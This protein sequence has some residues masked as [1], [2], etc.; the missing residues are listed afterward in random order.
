MSTDQNMDQLCISTMRTLSI[1]AIQ[2]AN[3]G[4]PGTPLDAA[5]FAYTLWQQFLRY[6]PADPEWFN[7]DRFVLSAGHGSMLLYAL[8]HL[9]GIKATAPSYGERLGGPA[10][11]LDDL[12]SF[13]Q[14]HS[15]CPGHP[16]Y[17]LT[18]GVEG[19]TGPLGQGV[20]MGVGMA[21]AQSY[22]AAQYNRPGFPIVDFQVYALA[23]DGCMMEGLS[24][25][26]ASLAG[27]LKLGNLCWIYDRNRVT[28]EGHT[29]LAFTEDV[30]ARFLTYGWHVTYVEDANDLAQINQ[31][32]QVAK[33]TS[34]RPTLIICDSHI[35]YGAPNKQD[36]A[37]AHGE[38]L[39]AEEA[40]LTKKFYGWDP[41]AEFLVPAGVPEHFQ[42]QM[43]QRGAE[44]RAAWETLFAS[45]RQEHPE[46]AAEID[47]MQNRELPDDWDQ[48]LVAYDADPKGQATRGVSGTV[49]NALAPRVPWLIG[50]SADLAPS[51]KTT[52]THKDAGTFQADNYGGRN[53][54]FGVREHAMCA[55]A[56][57]MSLAKVRPYVAGFFVFTDYSRPAMRIAALMEIPVIYVWTHDSVS[58][59]EDGPTHQPV[60]H[61][62]SFRAMPGMRILRP[63]DA[64][65][66]VEAYRVIMQTDDRPTCL[67]LSRQALPILDRQR[68]GAAKGLAR[69]AYV[70]AD[71]SDGKPDVI[72]IG[73]GSEVSL[74]VG[75]YEKM[76][77]EG[78]QVRVVSMPS[79]DLFEA[80]DESYRD[81]VLP[82]QVTARVS[83]EG[84]STFGWERYVG[85]T[86]A[87]IGMQSFG[88]SAP[89]DVVE[90]FFGFTE[91][92]VINAAKAQIEKNRK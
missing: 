24:S 75:A 19:T 8:I 91:E 74:C 87:M 3:S 54:H 72:L 28:I 57:G 52:L 83:V 76:T 65:E 73:S 39:G 59:G 60:E 49:L 13:R 2:K 26:A 41:D 10:L 71:A 32:L 64:N 89:G 33:D 47:A 43:G 80:Q 92:N 78:L 50:G 66:V 51:T 36:T 82:R 55:I 14:L 15:L 37:S 27:H 88:A 5:P 90:E 12:K 79:W 29:D 35:G 84:G 16:E 70:V 86:G 61:L 20:A 1:D 4:H 23:G 77:A 81:Q 11:T 17:G 69:G 31:S 45:Y 38:P 58:V 30:G 63:A 48:D 46:L 42:A 21:I 62:A 34:D 44:A 25:E 18:S 22:L 40:K 6:D 53:F 9:T 56:N 7:R 68:Y 67:V 85:M